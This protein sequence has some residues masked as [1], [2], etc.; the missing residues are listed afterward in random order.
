MRSTSILVRTITAVA[1]SALLFACA[2]A[3]RAGAKA[4][5]ATSPG[6]GGESAQ[7]PQQPAGYP[8]QPGAQPQP[9]MPAPPPPEPGA[10]PPA[11]GQPGGGG[12]ATSRTMAFS[13][14]LDEIDTSGRQ[15]DV[16]AGDCSNACRALGSMDRACGRL[17]SLAQGSD[18]TRR[19]ED[20]KKKVYS[21]RDR[22]KQTCT[23]CPGGI[24]VERS[25]P[26]P[27]VR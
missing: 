1:S 2:A 22:V 17:C 25:A 20:A 5:A 24:S 6:Y 16:A 11:P 19:C 27:S 15:L 7:Y 23:T 10:A 26:I 13:S 4:P 8:Q 14:A 18:E 21:A 3:D 9:G 12:S